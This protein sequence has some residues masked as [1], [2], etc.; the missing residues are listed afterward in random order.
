VALRHV[1]WLIAVGLMMASASRADD[2]E[3]VFIGVVGREPSASAW[4]DDLEDKLAVE[5]AKKGVRDGRAAAG[6][7]NTSDAKQLEKALDKARTSFLRGEFND[8]ATTAK[9][10]IQR[11][12]TSRVAD[13]KANWQPWFDAHMIWSAA[14]RR[15]NQDKEANRISRRA[16]VVQPRLPIDPSLVPPKELD[17][18]EALRTKVQNELVT[19][20]ASGPI[21]LDGVLMDE[22][23][24]VPAGEHWVALPGDVSSARRLD[25][26]T[27]C[28]AG[29]LSGL[30]ADKILAKLGTRELPAPKDCGA[31]TIAGVAMA[32]EEGHV[33]ALVLLDHGRVSRVV[34]T[35]SSKRVAAVAKAVVATANDGWVDSPTPKDGPRSLVFGAPKPAAVVRRLDDPPPA[36]VDDGGSVWPWVVGGVGAVV[37]AGA[38]VGVTWY[39]LQ[40]EAANQ[41]TVVRIDSSRL[42]GQR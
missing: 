13:T 8:A 18:V 30:Q 12:E 9:E 38:A 39:V 33:L 19:V 6:K 1:G 42:G 25:C 20:T 26:R 31:Q 40:Q 21:I 23:A 7:T 34:A 32:H 5:L 3:M 17:S 27:D 16:L 11:F 2:D 22:D 24:Q 4:A 29:P 36:E 10:L 37:V 14:E 28:Q 41:G 35:Q 15:S